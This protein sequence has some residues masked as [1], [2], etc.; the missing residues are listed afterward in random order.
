[1]VISIVNLK[2]IRKFFYF[3]KLNSNLRKFNFIFFCYNSKLDA[4]LQTLLVS[5]NIKF[6]FL[7]KLKYNNYLN[8]ILLPYLTNNLSIYCCSDEKAVTAI[9]PKISKY[10]I[11]CKINNNFYSLNNCEIYLTSR[12]DLYNYLSN[13]T[14]QFLTLIQNSSK[15]H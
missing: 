8:Y 10:L 15:I 7:K 6:Y 13:Y 12:I 5:Y 11:F 3:L 14:Y 9:L 1:M 4:N 2:L